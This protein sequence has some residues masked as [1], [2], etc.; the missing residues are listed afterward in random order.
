ML[1]VVSF[2]VVVIRVLRAERGKINQ[3][4]T[5]V[6]SDSKQYQT[7]ARELYVCS[8]ENF[9]QEEQ[10][11]RLHFVGSELQRSLHLQSRKHVIRRHLRV[12]E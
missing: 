8:Q 3:R 11:I 9:T 4:Q 5:A 12:S 10:R 6:I 7:P 1:L 2:I